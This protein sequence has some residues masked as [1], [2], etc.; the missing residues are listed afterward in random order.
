LIFCSN[1]GNLSDFVVQKPLVKNTTGHSAAEYI[2]TN[3]VK[4]NMDFDEDL[5]AIHSYLC[6]DGY[7]VRNPPTQKHK[8]Y[9]IGLR[10]TNIVL[11]KDFQERV[12]RRF[13]INPHLH[14]GQRCELSSKKL[15][16]Y[17][18]ENYS[19]YSREW[20]LP[21]LSKHNLAAWLRAFFDCESWVFVKKGQDRRI[22]VDS[23]NKQ[24]LLAVQNALNSLGIPSKFKELTKREMFRLYI[25]GKNNFVQFEKEI[26]FL[27]PQ[28]KAKLAQAINSYVTYDW[29]FPDRLCEQ[30]IF[31]KELLKQKAHLNKNRIR[32]YSILQNNLSTFST[33]M[34]KLYRVESKVYGPHV[35]GYGTP[36]YEFLIHKKDSLNLLLRHSLLS[37]ELGNKLASKV[38]K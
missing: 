14:P 3:F 26:G 30:R 31:V 17:F 5:A 20:E 11:L 6:A 8:Y 9:R 10:N 29:H 25:Y 1:F 32:L 21:K 35:N 15:Y 38:F 13:G 27:H 4:I 33:L 37:R 2:N 28:K 18:T 36:Y 34:S 7:V 12:F 19:F 22:G 23:V 16:F 24:G